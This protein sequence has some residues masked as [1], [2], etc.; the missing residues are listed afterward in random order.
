MGLQDLEN[1]T[2]M[3]V[4]KENLTEIQ[5]KNVREQDECIFSMY[6]LSHLDVREA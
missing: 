2:L 4:Y 5:G 3:V 6:I 1:K